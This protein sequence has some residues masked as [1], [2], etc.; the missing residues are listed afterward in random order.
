MSYFVEKCRVQKISIKN[1]FMFCFIITALTI[2]ATGQVNIGGVRIDVKKPE[3]KRPDPKNPTNTNGNVNTNPTQPQTNGGPSRELV[4]AFKED[5]K[6]YRQG[7]FILKNML[8]NTDKSWAPFYNEEMIRSGLQAGAGLVELVRQKYPN[9]QDPNWAS[10]FED[11]I[12]SWHQIAETRIE[13]AKNYL[14]KRIGFVMEERA[15]SLNESRAKIQLKDGFVL[16]RDFADRENLRAELGKEY[17]PM[18]ALVNMKPDASAFAPYE[19]ALD[20]L[21]DEAKKHVGEWKWYGIFHDAAGE[22]KGRGWFKN[23]EPNGQLVKIGF[24]HDTWQVNMQSNGI[25]RGRYKRGYVM[26]RKQGVEQCIVA[27]FSYEQN[28][29]GGGRYNDVANTSG[30]SY[31]VRLQSCK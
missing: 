19:T 24:E 5:A 25:P 23:F 27:N 22:A 13:I 26:Y 17:N 21:I 31:I 20:A 12:G 15:K 30:F 18:F 16:H 28:Y 14:N 4:K 9:I 29:M 2:S 1:V 10:Q 3:T 6:D 8:D 7:I 11:K